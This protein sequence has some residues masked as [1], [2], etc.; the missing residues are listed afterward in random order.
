M[1]L[2]GKMFYYCFNDLKREGDTIIFCDSLIKCYTSF[3]SWKEYFSWSDRLPLSVR[4]FHEVILEGPQK[5]RVDLDGIDVE[6]KEEVTIKVVKAIKDLFES[7][8]LI[9]NIIVYASDGKR[10]MSRHIIVSN[11]LFPSSV[12]CKA[13]LRR[14]SIECQYIDVGVYKSFQCFRLEG[15]TKY[16]ELREKVLFCPSTIPF[17]SKG[18]LTCR[19][20][21]ELLPLPNVKEEKKITTGSLNFDMHAFKVRHSRGNIVYLDRIFP[22]YCTLCKRVHENE[23]AFLTLD[24]YGNAKFHCFRQDS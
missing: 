9:P 5:F 22:S 23:N 4:N 7:V 20:E 19:R 10:K 24:E 15:S 18:T 13:I 1:E 12:H 21:T 6:N 8:S 11:Y 2:Y 17:R 3:T 14:L 16:G